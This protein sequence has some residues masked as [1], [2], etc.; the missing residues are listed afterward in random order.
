MGG[1]DTAGP[2]C[3]VAVALTP[4]VYFPK[5]LW[6]VRWTIMLEPTLKNLE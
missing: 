5:V 2:A 3:V 1:A 6:G 4:R